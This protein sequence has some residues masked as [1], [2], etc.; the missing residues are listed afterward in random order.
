MIVSRW[1]KETDNGNGR[2]TRTSSRVVRLQDN[3]VYTVSNITVNRGDVEFSFRR[4][5][6]TKATARVE[7]IRKSDAAVKNRK[8][9]KR[10]Y[11]V[12]ESGV[13]NFEDLI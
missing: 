5:Y 4:I 13:I 2:V 1:E 9:A 3:R 10:D 8:V 12:M 7:A 11:R 6:K